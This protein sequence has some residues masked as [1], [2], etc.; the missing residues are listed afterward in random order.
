MA[1]EFYVTI[2][3]TKQGKFKGETN[4]GR[5]A[6]KL[7]A[8]K[9]PGVRF[10][11]ETTSPRD[12]ATG[13]ASGKRRHEPIALTKEWGAASPQ[14]FQALVTNEILKSVLFEFVRT[15]ANGQASVHH[16]IKLTNATVVSLKSYL[17]L[18]DTTGD[19]FDAHELE[20]VAFTFQKVEIAN[21]G[22]KTQAVDDWH[23]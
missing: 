10:S 15:N 2:E 12:A 4:G 11:A 20:D 9:I 3:G 19:R 22:G 7:G 16:T 8:G 6:T 23:V 14:L 21:L 18:T 5:G 1:S 13:Q 17:D